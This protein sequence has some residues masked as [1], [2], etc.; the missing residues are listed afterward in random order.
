[1]TPKDNNIK[2]INGDCLTEIKKL[3]PGSVDLVIT[4]PPYNLGVF[5]KERNTNINALRENHFCGAGWDD[6]NYKDWLRVM[7][8]FFKLLSR[9]V[10]NGGSVIVF[11]AI[12]KVE[13]IISIAQKYG[14]YYKTTGIWHK[15]NPM[16]RNMNLHFI[17]STEAWIYFTK[18]VKTGT[19][20]NNNKAFHDFIEVPVTP[21]SEKKF[22]RHP[23]QKPEKLMRFFIKLLSNEGD[24]VF[25]PFMGTGVTGCVSKKMK[26]NFIGIELNEQYFKIAQKRIEAVKL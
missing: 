6:L 11:M 10:K 9:T 3:S 1:M 18:K 16:P 13:T 24:C 2:I 7:N 21:L 8:Y 23:T 22:G 15:T 14:F 4:D 12:I 26:R 17:N 5:M 19:F 25:D 20:N